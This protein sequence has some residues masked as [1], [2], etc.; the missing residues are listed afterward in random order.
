M[1]R[2]GFRVGA[3]RPRLPAEEI[4]ANT[5]DER[6][7]KVRDALQ[8]LDEWDIV[9]EGICRHVRAMVG[10]NS[11][12]IVERALES[13]QV[14]EEMLRK[15]EAPEVRRLP[16]DDALLMLLHLKL[17]QHQYEQLAK[18]MNQ[19]SGTDSAEHMI[20][21]YPVIS[22]H[23][24][25]LRPANITVTEVK[26]RVPLQDLLQHTLE[27]MVKSNEREILDMLKGKDEQR[28]IFTFFY[29]YDS[30]TGQRKYTQRYK[31]TANESRD[32]KS[33]IAG[34]VNPYALKTED[35]IVLCLNK[36]V[37]SSLFI[38]TFFLEYATETTDYL[39]RCANIF[40]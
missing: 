11:R 33:L 2:G 21:C 4:A 3:G 35:G 22:R 36:Y 31:N 13:D 39:R 38:R 15:L 9:K 29:G 32:D 10:R 40:S 28:C 18:M 17:S 37:Q 12:C 5:W 19:F 7:R 30:C 1:P 34:V 26:A 24:R 27:R 6:V 23:K 8:E 20:P 14:A 16:K 25:T